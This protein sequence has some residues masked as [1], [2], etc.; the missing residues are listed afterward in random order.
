MKLFKKKDLMDK[1]CLSLNDLLSVWGE[2]DKEV[3]ISSPLFKR[4]KEIAEKRYGKV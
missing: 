2:E 1:K 4:F 3:Y